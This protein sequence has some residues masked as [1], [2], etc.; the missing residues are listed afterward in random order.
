MTDF[1]TVC[2]DFVVDKNR[3][4]SPI[5]RFVRE[6]T[7]FENIVELKNDILEAFKLFLQYPLRRNSGIR[8]VRI[9][10]LSNTG[11]VLFTA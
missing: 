7:A 8:L 5:V 3:N 11:G 2:T 4:S 9:Y 10:H 1:H 6:S